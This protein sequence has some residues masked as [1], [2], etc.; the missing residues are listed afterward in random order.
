MPINLDFAWRSLYRYRGLGFERGLWLPDPIV[1]FGE[2]AFISASPGSQVL[3][4]RMF[5]SFVSHARSQRVNLAPALFGFTIYPA[6]WF[7][8]FPS[9]GL[10]LSGLIH[11]RD[12]HPFLRSPA[13]RCCIHRVSHPRKTVVCELGPPFTPHFPA[14][15]LGICSHYRI[16]LL[17]QS[18]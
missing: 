1:D 15:T 4:L 2:G 8:S 13:N 7:S 18:F 3:R 11:K 14:P 5:E 17:V 6:R 12:A 10:S 9:D 16:P